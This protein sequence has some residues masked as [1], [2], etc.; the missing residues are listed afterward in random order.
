MCE[1]IGMS[2]LVGDTGIVGDGI[3][4]EQGNPPARR[5]R[6]PIH[7]TRRSFAALSAIVASL[8]VI[9]LILAPTGHTTAHPGNTGGN[10]GNCH[11]APTST[12]E[13]IAGL[14]AGTYSPGQAYSVTV[15]VADTNGA[16]GE[17]SFDF[18]VSAGTVTSSDPNVKIVSAKEAAATVYTVSSWTL[19]WTAPT[20]GSVSVDG[21]A[22]FGGGQLQNSPY[23][24]LT[25]TLDPVAIPEFTML[26]VPV[27][28][29]VG[30]I[31]VATRVAK[32]KS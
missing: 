21:W 32:K 29:M 4:S 11:P 2:T 14:P 23:N 6:R 16:T 15:S 10:C 5:T 7:V 12:F 26:L 19:T 30:A 20:T 22:V 25:Y 28:G 27:V 9:A 24:H 1:E 3:G 8:G 17:N 31:F 18:I 13:T